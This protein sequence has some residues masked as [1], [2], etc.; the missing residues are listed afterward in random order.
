MSAT[1]SEVMSATS[2]RLV[3]PDRWAEKVS[4]RRAREILRLKFE[5]G[6][7]DRRIAVAVSVARLLIEC[8]FRAAA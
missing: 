5:H 4:M 1:D 7:S 3:L 6:A 8:A 2:E